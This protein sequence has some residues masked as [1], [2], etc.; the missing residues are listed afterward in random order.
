MDH[1]DTPQQPVPSH[2]PYKLNLAAFVLLPNPHHPTSDISSIT[3]STWSDLL[4]T[5]L[6]A[7][8]ATIH[9]FLPLFTSRK[10]TLL[11]L[12]PSINTSF[13]APS[14]AAESVITGGI[15]QYISTLRK[16]ISS[17]DVSLVEVKLGHFNY[18]TAQAN[19]QQLVISQS[20][21]RA[22]AAERR[23]KQL[24][25]MKHAVKGSSLRLLQN[26]VFDAIVRGKGRNGTIFVGQGSRVYDLVGRW[27]PAGVIGWMLGQNPVPI[28]VPAASFPGKA[29]SESSSDESAEAWEN[30]EQSA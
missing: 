22:D 4:N 9:A 25:V 23:V 6:L 27:I 7:P 18:E 29:K 13:T 10:T 24:G 1:L 21:S 19:H 3:P 20:S 11:F 2:P 5:Q 12:N 26:G 30:I 15:Q 17:Q 16:E 8:F 14:H 28:P